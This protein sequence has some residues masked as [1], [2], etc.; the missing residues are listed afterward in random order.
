MC[1][2]FCEFLYVI[3]LIEE[4]IEEKYWFELGII[5]LNGFGYVFVILGCFSYNNW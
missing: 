4:V 5:L 2:G 3:E 1:C